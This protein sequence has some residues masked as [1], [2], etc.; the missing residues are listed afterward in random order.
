MRFSVNIPAL[1]QIKRSLEGGQMLAAVDKLESA[2][3]FRKLLSVVLALIALALVAGGVQLALLGG[4]FYYILAGV[5]V[6]LSAW[7][8]FKGDRRGI[9]AYGLMLLVT[10]VWAFWEGGLD[11]WRLQSRLFGPLLLGV[12]VAWPLLSKRRSYLIGAFGALAILLV[13]WIYDVGGYA[14]ISSNGRADAK[15]SLAALADVSGEWRN[16][17]NDIAGSRHSPLDQITPANVSELEP[18]WT[19]RTGVIKKSGMGFEATPLMVNDTVYLCTSNNIVSA[20][21]PETGA[22]RWVFDPKTKAPPSGACR[23]VG[24]YEVPGATGACAKRVIMNTVDARLMEVD[25]DTGKPCA[26]FGVN[27]SVDLKKGLGDV[28]PGYYYVSSAP[29]IVRGKVI[30]GGWV[31]DGQFVGEPSGVVRAFDVVTGKFVWSWDMDRPDFNGEPPEGQHYSR[32]TPNVWGT[33]SAD[34]K[35]G[36][37]Y[38]P[39][40]NS[41]PDYWGA[42]RSPESEKHSSSV[43]ALDVETGKQRW[44]FQTVHHD[45]WDYDVSAQPTLIDLPIGGKTVPALIQGTKQGQVYLLDR[46]NGKPLATVEEKPVPQGPPPGDWLARTQPFSTGMPSFDATVLTERHM[47]GLTPLDQL[48]CRIKFKKARYEGPFTPPGV[49]PSIT[50]PSYLGGINWGGVSVDPER[51]LLVVNWS[52]MANYTSIVGRK[53]ADKMGVKISMDGGAH[54]GIPVPQMGTPYA[55]F[56]GAFLSPLDVPCTEPPFGKIT[57]VDLDTHKILWEKPLGTGADSGPWA[58]RSHVPLPMGVP[59]TGGS[60]T[61]RSGLV[62][63]GATQERAFRAFDINTGKLLWRAP[64]PAGGHATPM[65]YVSKKSG[66]QFVVIAAGGS[67]PLYSGYGDYVMA[68]AL[69]KKK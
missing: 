30:I 17:G 48:W 43:T 19:Y 47:W 57:V 55:L 24:F 13:A 5:L 32:G 53:E 45:V 50:Y 28:I 31:F 38:M 8:V 16:Y 9:W 21:D 58:V 23:G 36:L 37:V 4:S 56:T 49:K 22:K 7:F 67:A 33:M 14:V 63:I 12:W 42:H 60:I 51:R 62:F 44:T 1:S 18:A 65:T 68:Y 46:T 35:L 66:R 26:D 54:V 59:N 10:L 6:G 3:F 41:T 64:L 15:P 27:G 40:G 29:L 52:R 11:P 34:E 25:A 2:G 20:L 39:I 69:P 61:T